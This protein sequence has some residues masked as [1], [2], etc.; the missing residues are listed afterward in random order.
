MKKKKTKRR[1]SRKRIDKL[2]QS[3]KRILFFF[4]QISFFSNGL[5]DLAFRKF[6]EVVGKGN[7]V[8]FEFQFGK[9]RCAMNF[10]LAVLQRSDASI[11]RLLDKAA[12][13]TLYEFM[14]QTQHWV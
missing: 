3:I 5:T 11:V 9:V 13:V 4:C 6:L 1:L 10:N 7:K 2:S 12:H 8:V 14:H